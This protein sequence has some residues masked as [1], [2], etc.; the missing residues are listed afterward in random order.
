MSSKPDKITKATLQAVA[1][2]NS[3]ALGYFRKIKTLEFASLVLEH[4]STECQEHLADTLNEMVS[5]A[6]GVWQTQI[7]DWMVNILACSSEG[8]TKTLDKLPVY[9]ADSFQAY[10]KVIEDGKV[11]SVASSLK[12]RVD[13][14]S[15]SAKIADCPTEFLASL[16]LWP[17]V[18]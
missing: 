1:T 18:V 6:D 10:K 3:T 13:A 4:E 8:L 17:F 14:A 15:C 12:K 5:S 9:H 11:A 2:A 7:K 16:T